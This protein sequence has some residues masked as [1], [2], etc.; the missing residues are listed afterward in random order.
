MVLQKILAVALILLLFPFSVFALN[1]IQFTT[2]TD[3][4][5]L[6]KDTA[7][8]STITVQASGVISNV[9][10]ETNYID[11]T[12]DNGSTLTLSTADNVY[13]M[14]TVQSGSGDSISPTCPLKSISILS[15]ANVVVRI[16]LI[17]NPPACS[18]NNG[19]NGNGN[20]N[21]K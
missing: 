20:G 14:A 11:V 19:N 16:E 1:D 4:Q 2:D 5:L 3:I 8:L 15:A 18:I 21:N 10:I 9:L 7:V 13:F 6:T 12:L 17:S